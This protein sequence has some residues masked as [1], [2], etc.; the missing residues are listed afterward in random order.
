EMQ[1]ASPR[2]ATKGRARF[3]QTVAAGADRG[4]S[5]SNG[6]RI[7]PT[8]IQ[9][10]RDFNFERMPG[11]GEDSFTCGWLSPSGTRRRRIKRS[12][13]ERGKTMHP[14]IQLKNTTALI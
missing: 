13:K 5:K 7:F 6:V 12:G 14:F 10:S 8:K 3:P 9:R 1:S 2:Y 11:Q 4:F